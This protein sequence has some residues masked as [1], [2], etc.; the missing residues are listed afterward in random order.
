M[1]ANFSQEL[2]NANGAIPII[3]SKKLALAFGVLGNKITEA[4]T[5]EN[6]AGEIKEAGDRVRIVLP[7]PTGIEIGEGDMCPTFKNIAP[8]ALD[9]VVDKKMSFGLAIDDVQK[10][11]T[12]FKNWLDGQ[13]TAH[14][15]AIMKKKNM[16]YAREM[17]E[18]TPGEKVQ[19]VY[20]PAK[21]P[22]ALELGTDAAPVVVTPKNV[23]AF[24]LKIKEALF[25]SGAIGEDGTYSYKPM[26]EEAR[27]ERG[28]LV[29][30]SRLHTIM[31]CS[32]QIGGRSVEMADVAVK[33]GKVERV[34]G[35][36]I[37][38]D[39][40][41]DELTTTK[42]AGTVDPKDGTRHKF[43]NI[44]FL[45]GTKNAMTRAAQISKVEAT[46]DPYCFR[47]LI[48]GL[49]LYGYKLIH[50]ECLVRGVVKAIDIDALGTEVPV[51]VENG[52]ANP[53]NTKE[54]QG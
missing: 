34:A 53:V 18:Y 28:V 49:E 23:F 10:A 26:E 25:Q 45:A 42:G 5:N 33:D 4:L 15:Q 22:L 40:T 21:H 6:W 20:D 36:D 8:E 52:T 27:E 14:A 43:A 11:Q 3:F 12:Q 38:I 2:T 47:D 16:A 1:T 41:L 50:P 13:A 35:L 19:G 7:D 54:V 32:Y 31:L 29:V 37:V 44:P 46:R 9:M 30:P 51:V 24:I 48:K 17:F 39:K